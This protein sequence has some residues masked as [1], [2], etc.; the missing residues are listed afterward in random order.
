MDVAG[1]PDRC[2]P[3][4]QIVNA[5]RRLRDGAI[6]YKIDWSRTQAWHVGYE[7]KESIP[8]RKLLAAERRFHCRR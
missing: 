3:Y 4:L 2:Y 6:C 1:N 5:K 8:L 7:L